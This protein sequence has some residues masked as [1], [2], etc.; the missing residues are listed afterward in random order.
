MPQALHALFRATCMRDQGRQRPQ[1][2]EWTQDQ[3][4]PRGGGASGKSGAPACIRTG[5]QRLID[6]GAAELVVSIYHG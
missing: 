2:Y 1:A 3:N 6:K 5:A 4:T